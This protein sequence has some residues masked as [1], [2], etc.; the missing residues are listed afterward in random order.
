MQA[1]HTESITVPKPKFSVQQ[2]PG[3]WSY[4]VQTSVVSKVSATRL[5]CIKYPQSSY[6]QKKK[7]ERKITF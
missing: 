5:F 2:V 7:K 3:V 1:L 6:I 4:P